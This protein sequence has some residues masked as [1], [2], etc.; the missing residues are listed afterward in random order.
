MCSAVLSWVG[1]LNKYKKTNKKANTKNIL[2]SFCPKG[3]FLF[4]DHNIYKP[5]LSLSFHMKVLT[6]TKINQDL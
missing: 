5:R 4:L 2:L 1:G 6:Y 3:K